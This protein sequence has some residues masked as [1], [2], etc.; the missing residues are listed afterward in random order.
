L[1]LLQLREKDLPAGD[2]E[3]LARRTLESARR[4]GARVL[5]N[6]SPDVARRCGADGIHLTS[7]QLRALARRP[8]GFDLV[9]AS[10]HDAEEL[11]QARI[12]DADF[13]VLGPVQPTASHVGVRSLGWLPFATLI[14]DYP[15]PVYALGGMQTSDLATAWQAGAHGVSMMRGAWEQ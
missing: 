4:H 3:A 8:P 11:A 14:R 1:K 2:L 12:I 13:V 9:G 5:I 6:G 7:A 10:C 15:L